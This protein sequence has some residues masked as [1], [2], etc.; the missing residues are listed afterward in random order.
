MASSRPA[1]Y[2]HG[3]CSR[4][5]LTPHDKDQLNK[6]LHGERSNIGYEK[7]KG[8]NI[9]SIRSSQERRI[10]F[11]PF[12][13]QGECL[14]L[15]LEILP[16]HDYKNAKCLKAGIVEAFLEKNSRGITINLESGNIEV[17]TENSD[18]PFTKNPE[19]QIEWAE[20]DRY[21]GQFIS[22]SQEQQAFKSS[23]SMPLILCGPAGSGKTSTAI[24]L[25]IDIIEQYNNEGITPDYPIAY[26]SDKQKLITEVERAWN[27]TDNP[28]SKTPAG[29]S[30][31]FLSSQM[32][33][34]RYAP[35]REF[36]A[37]TKDE[38]IAC[39]RN[40]IK[41]LSGDDKH[42]LLSL[43][44]VKLIHEGGIVMLCQHKDDYINLGDS[45][46]NLTDELRDHRSLFWDMIYKIN[47]A[48]KHD[49][50]IIPEFYRWTPEIAFSTTIFDE[51]QVGSP[52]TKLMA[53]QLTESSRIVIC[54]DALQSSDK[55][56]PDVSL[57]RK[58]L[59]SKNK[60]ATVIKLNKCFRTPEKI[61]QFA[62]QLIHM[63]RYLNGGLA[64]QTEQVQLETAGTKSTD[65][66][67]LEWIDLNKLA[68]MPGQ[69]MYS[70]V[71]TAIVTHPAFIEEAYIRFNTGLVFTPNDIGGLEFENIVLYRLTESKPALSTSLALADYKP[72]EK[73]SI[74]TPK[75]NQGNIEHALYCSELYTAATRAMKQL[76]VIEAP[77]KKGR[78]GDNGRR[79]LLGLLKQTIERLNPSNPPGLAVNEASQQPMD[80]TEWEKM[81]EH[82]VSS[83]NIEQAKKVWAINLKRDVSL[84]KLSKPAS[85]AW[86]LDTA[87]AKPL[88][89][90][91]IKNLLKKGDYINQFTHKTGRH[92]LPLILQILL[93]EQ[94]STN[95]ILSIVD[96]NSKNRVLR[97]IESLDMNSIVIFK[98]QSIPL[99]HYLFNQPIACALLAKLAMN[100]EEFL[101]S[102][103]K[104]SHETLTRLTQSEHADHPTPALIQLSYTNLALFCKLI[105][106]NDIELHQHLKPWWTHTASKDAN[107]DTESLVKRVLHFASTRTNQS[108]LLAFMKRNAIHL[109]LTWLFSTVTLGESTKLLRL[110]TIIKTSEG[111]RLIADS[112]SQ[113]EDSR[114]FVDYLTEDVLLGE[115]IGFGDYKPSRLFLLLKSVECHPLLKRFFRSHVQST[116]RVA[117]E[118]YR[119]QASLYP[120]NGLGHML[121]AMR[122]SDLLLFLFKEKPDIIN[123]IPN[124]AWDEPGTVD[125]FTLFQAFL[126]N[127]SE[128]DC[129]FIMENYPD[130]YFKNTSQD[131]FSDSED[132]SDSDITLGE[133]FDEFSDSSLSTQEAEEDGPMSAL[134]SADNPSEYLACENG[135]GVTNFERICF[136][137]RLSYELITYISDL[138][139]DDL[140]KLFCR[141]NFNAPTKNLPFPLIHRMLDSRASFPLLS[142]L[143]MRIPNAIFNTYDKPVTMAVA[144]QGYRISELDNEFPSFLVK[145]S[146]LNTALLAK[147][148]EHIPGIIQ[149]TEFSF[150][151]K[152]ELDSEEEAYSII[153]QLALN[154][155]EPHVNMTL[156]RIM[157]ESSYSIFKSTRLSVWLTPQFKHNNNTLSYI[158][159]FDRHEKTKAYVKIFLNTTNS[160]QWNELARSRPDIIRMINIAENNVYVSIKATMH[161]HIPATASQGGPM[162][163]RTTATLFSQ[164]QIAMAAIR[165]VMSQNQNQKKPRK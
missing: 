74:H 99:L 37:L 84:F 6:L 17:I 86:N 39:L 28:I 72:D 21:H 134:L 55:S 142:V 160:Y 93:N 49:K 35:D 67:S 1:F 62:N 105:N 70:S 97:I 158:E 152:L 131:L 33:L 65:L 53:T 89:A 143:L 129:R 100:H 80:D 150:W 115:V 153:S 109:D 63:R 132:Q 138:E 73:T 18:D 164:Q 108:H 9:Y 25:L 102:V 91:K 151:L 122:S 45:D 14:A 119:V 42:P 8:V 88:S 7:L 117:E 106:S 110:D 94:S 11:T 47:A 121:E 87:D 26:I 10:L 57:L 23:Q 40:Q 71:T 68:A 50:Q 98:A 141:V 111:C 16:T 4:V 69:A 41:K 46:S 22:L 32:L 154:V 12:I 30:I 64:D 124:D 139:D 162:V 147:V 161:K 116:N 107:Q 133:S 81:I 140:I 77:L 27:A 130:L 113:G 149:K 43:S 34:E 78:R 103:L 123:A 59:G 144:K 24:S 120:H 127:A 148:I 38:T 58:K 145:L 2:W 79:H 146:C 61:T 101:F 159:L 135:A 118:L 114:L 155:D 82:L 48:I 15:V 60:P 126:D 36:K 95:L 156:L 157:S 31:E 52:V 75:R 5:D 76:T 66:G 165:Q 163:Q 128:A 136:D 20:L 125:E 137:A 83:G 29:R 104:P 3:F 112:L 90:A 54:V 19:A 92:P 96:A 44:D 56:R 13:H 51:G 85:A